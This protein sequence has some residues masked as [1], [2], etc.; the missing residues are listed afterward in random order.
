MAAAGAGADALARVDVF[1]NGVNLNKFIFITSTFFSPQFANDSQ[2]DAAAGEW[3]AKQNEL[4][5][6]CSS[7]TLSPFNAHRTHTHCT[8]DGD[9]VP[10]VKSLH[11][12][13]KILVQ[14]ETLCHSLPH[15]TVNCSVEQREERKKKTT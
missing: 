6:H 12:I 3:Q 13:G 14:L 1:Q 15:C 8:R 7:I 11:A 4:E 9:D 5:R 2:I 10:L